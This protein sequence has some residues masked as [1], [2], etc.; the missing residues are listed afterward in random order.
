MQSN[1]ARYQNSSFSR[2]QSPFHGESDSDSIVASSESETDEPNGAPSRCAQPGSQNQTPPLVQ[3][4]RVR[5][6]LFD[7]QPDIG[8][9]FVERH[10]ITGDDWQTAINLRQWSSLSKAHHAEAIGLFNQD[11]LA[12]ASLHATRYAVPKDIEFILKVFNPG[13]SLVKKRLQALVDEYRNLYLNLGM[14]P[15]WYQVAAHFDAVGVVFNDRKLERLVVDIS[16][17]TSPHGDGLANE[18]IQAIISQLASAASA[19]RI[20]QRELPAIQLRYVGSSASDKGAWTVVS[21]LADNPGMVNALTSLHLGFKDPDGAGDRRASGLLPKLVSYLNQTT[22]LSTFS[23]T[24]TPLSGQ[25]C[26]RIA[27]ALTKNESVEHLQLQR[28]Q[29]IDADAD[30][31]LALLAKNDNI[32]LVNLQGNKIS[33]AHAIWNDPRVTGAGN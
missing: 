27:A 3:T 16:P 20:E 22:S 32:A 2:Q 26:S 21:T 19:A 17:E 31:L 10:L 30:K 23:V 6:H 1:A 12:A 25:R 13:K 9:L 5:S 7:D 14:R 29:L 18:A 8:R 15:K 4:V 33:P 11:R 28:C 24:D